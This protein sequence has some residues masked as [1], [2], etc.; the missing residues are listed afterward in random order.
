M[1]IERKRIFDCALALVFI[2]IT[3]F[4]LR[5]LTR[6]S[7]DDR[8]YWIGFVG[9]CILLELTYVSLHFS[10]KALFFARPHVVAML[11]RIVAAIV[12]LPVTIVAGLLMVIIGGAMIGTGADTLSYLV[13][14]M[15]ILA[16][17]GVPSFF[18]WRRVFRSST[19][20]EQALG[21]DSP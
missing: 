13:D 18:L 11:T 17:L 20:A 19:R 16:S 5:L 9:F 3:L 15:F 8:D 21:A 10:L 2:V 14:L 6:V 12:A 4:W 1:R 7:F